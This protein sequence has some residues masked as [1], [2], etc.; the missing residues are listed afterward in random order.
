[1]SS[2]KETGP[3]MILEAPILIGCVEDELC[4]AFHPEK[5]SP[6][7]SARLSTAATSFGWAVVAAALISIGALLRGVA[8]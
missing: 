5:A 1:M 6:R 7:K 3:S 4:S 2:P 8:V